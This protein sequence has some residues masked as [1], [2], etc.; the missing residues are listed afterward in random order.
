[1]E[2]KEEIQII[3]KQMAEEL[4][5]ELGL[6]PFPEDFEFIQLQGGKN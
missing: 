2:V 5:K 6:H 4:N 3:E 1:M